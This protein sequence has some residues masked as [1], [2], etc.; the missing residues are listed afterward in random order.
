M[1]KI[2]Q[3]E[4]RIEELR[5][6]LEHVEGTP[7]EVYSRIVGY[8]RPV[9]N[10][11]KGK[12]EEFGIR[13]TFSNTEDTHTSGKK[14]H[15]AAT[16]ESAVPGKAAD[17]T[18][19]LYFYRPTCPNCPAVARALEE[20]GLPGQAIDVDTDDGFAAAEQYNVLAAPTVIFLDEGSSEVLRTSSARAVR[21]AIPVGSAGAAV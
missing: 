9:S 16:V 2:E 12:L 21:S 18:S 15:K 7:T 5:Q 14:A 10:W 20:I 19:Y 4:R 17:I 11:N 8:Y 6:E 1:N 13:K 3:I